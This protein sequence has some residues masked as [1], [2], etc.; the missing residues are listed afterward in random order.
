MIVIIPAS[1]DTT[2][3]DDYG[4]GNRT[5]SWNCN[6]G[7]SPILSVYKKLDHTSG[8][9]FGDSYARSLVYFDLQNYHKIMNHYGFSSASISCSIKMYNAI[10]DLGTPSSYYLNIHPVTQSWDEGNGLD[11][12]KFADYGYCNWLSASSYN[13]WSSTGSDYDTNVSTSIYFDSGDED[14]YCDITNI[15]DYWHNSGNFGAIVKLDDSLEQ[16]DIDYY[17][18]KFYARHSINNRSWPTI[19]IKIPD[20]QKDRRSSIYLNKSGSIF[21]YNIYDGT[22]EDFPGVS[23]FSVTLYD[24]VNSASFSM[25][26][27]SSNISSGVY[28]STIYIP[29]YTGSILYD[30]W[31]SGGIDYYT[32][33]ITINDSNIQSNYSKSKLM[34][35][36][37]NLADSYNINELCTFD[38]FIRQFPWELNTWTQVNEDSNDA[39]PL[40]YD[41]VR[42]EIF[43]CYNNETVISASS[44]T[45]LSYNENG[46]YFNFPMMNLYDGYFKLLFC[47]SRNHNYELIDNNFKFRVTV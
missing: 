42:Y 12:I 16:N 10:H 28:A 36:M 33:S 13:S 27:T 46:H 21:L 9:L 11:D 1:K 31:S 41:D 35:S 8:S 47:V 39:I 30:V 18:K 44:Y 24:D 45:Q 26:F 15:W 3:I 17:V 19:E 5:S 2:L 20:V 43:D 6:L 29:E 37:P 14:L 34:V 32:G 4:T 23:V 38:V 25:S 7:Q 40:L 22:L